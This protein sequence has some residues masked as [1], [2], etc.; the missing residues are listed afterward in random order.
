MYIA[1]HIL[2]LLENK[3]DQT[4]TTVTGLLDLRY[5]R[6]RTE[7]VE[8]AIE[9]LFRFR[10]DDCEEDDALMMAMK[11]IRQTRMDSVDDVLVVKTYILDAEV[12]FLC[13]KQ[14]LE[15]WRFQIDGRDKIL[16][17]SSK[18]DGSRMKI[19]MIDTQGGHYAAVLEMHRRK[20]VLYLENAL[21]DKLGV[22]FLEDKVEELCSFKAVRHVHG[23]NCHKQKDQMIAA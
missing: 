6:S 4:I 5:G 18:T 22:L 20:N 16:E 21:G 1:D 12:P 2:P 11:E 3:E 9:D 13:S 14:T 17:I 10:E 19:K 15:D 8:E 23:V 7:R